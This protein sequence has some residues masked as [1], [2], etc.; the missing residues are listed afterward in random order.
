MLHRRLSPAAAAL[1]LTVAVGL[2]APRP[3]DAAPAAKGNGSAPALHVSGNRL[4]TATGTTYRLLGVNRSGG[5]FSCMQGKGMWDGPM[6]Q[7]SV[8]AM[9]SWNVRA[10][11]VPLN[12]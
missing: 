9:R 5:E 7:A 4:V 12:E 10:V 8:A 6:D 11:R 2:L 3:A 1:L